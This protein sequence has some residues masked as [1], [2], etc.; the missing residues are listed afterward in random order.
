[1]KSAIVYMQPWI[2]EAVL[3]KKGMLAIIPELP[4][5]LFQRALQGFSTSIW[6][7]FF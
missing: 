1:M 5:A 3:L 2:L 6:T 7:I 4:L